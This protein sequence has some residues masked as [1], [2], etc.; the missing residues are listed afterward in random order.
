MNFKPERAVWLLEHYFWLNESLVERDSEPNCWAI[1]P[2]KEHFPF[3]HAKTFEY[4]ESLFDRIK[5]CMEI[6]DWP[7]E[8]Q[9]EEQINE[10]SAEDLAQSGIYGSIPQ[11]SSAAGTF[12]IDEENQVVISYSEEELGNPI[13]LIAT[14]AHELCHYLIST[15]TSEPPCGWEDH[16]PLTDI[17]AVHEGF[18]IFLCNSAFQFG[19]FQDGQS[20]GWS[21]RSV[22]YL[23]ESELAFC[24][25][26]FTIHRSIDPALIAGH[27][28]ANCKEYYALALDDLETDPTLL[29]KMKTITT[30]RTEQCR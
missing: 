19:Q 11:S 20:H 28:K 8:L 12:S 30:S 14:M 26:I 15:I 7:C 29:Q 23:Q 5:E 16:E 3:K 18:G 13:S 4:A 25:A 6:S 27:L 10:V 22:G 1:F 21:S 24:L 2:T 17:A 9:S